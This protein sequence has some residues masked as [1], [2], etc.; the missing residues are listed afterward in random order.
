M[1]GRGDRPQRLSPARARPALVRE[2]SAGGLVY[3]RRKDGWAVVLAAR[4]HLHKGT[5]AWTIPKG[6]VE[7]GESTA[8]AALREVR[9]E[10]GLTAAIDQPLGDV[11]Y[12]YVRRAEAGETVRVFKR[13]RFFLMRRL[14][15]RFR[16]RDEEMEAVRWFCIDQAVVRA[17][18]ANERALVQRA[19]AVL[20]GQCALRQPARRAR[21]R[22]ASAARRSRGEEPPR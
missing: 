19:R 11:T 9:E 21:S 18:H 10:T 3:R 14:G 8:S 16:D 1:A 7:R 2:F 12:W 13:V 22:S 6:H 4:R 17:A 15:G 20:E 5:L